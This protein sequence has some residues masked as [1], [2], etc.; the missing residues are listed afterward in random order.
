MKKALKGLSGIK[1]FELL[2]NTET[3]YKVGE[4]IP[5]PYAQKLTRDVQSSSDP[6]YA[7]DDIYDDEEIIEGED[8]EMEIPEADLSMF[9]IL[10]GGTY[11]ESTK[12]YSWGG[13]AGK[14]Y[15]MTFKS[16]KKDGNYR[17][18]RYYRT[19][20]KKVKQDLQTADNGTSIS[21]L[22]ISGTFYRRMYRQEGEA[23]PS[24]RTYKDSETSSDLTWLD[25]IPAIPTIQDPEISEL[26]ISV[27]EGLTTATTSGTKVADLSVEGGTAPFVY[28]LEEQGDS[29]SFEIDGTTVKAKTNLTVAKNMSIT[30]T[31]TDAKG[32]TMQET[33]TI[34]VVAG[35]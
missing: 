31:V 35:E 13:N 17:M 10:E 24:M 30:V 18:F 14:E 34:E 11:D 6:I 1:V 4:A 15:A 27:V 22:T 32:K 23:F 29:D 26:I 7:D 20:F 25:T 8:F 9:P 28:T 21:T 33:A 2:K 3:E 12:E 19:K 5:I 16:K